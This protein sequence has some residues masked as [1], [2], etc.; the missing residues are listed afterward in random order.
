MFFCPL[1]R[2]LQP[3]IG[4]PSKYLS[5]RLYARPLTTSSATLAQQNLLADTTYEEEWAS[6][7]EYN[8]I[9]GPTSIGLMMD[10]LPGGE[11]Y[12]A[13]FLKLYAT[14]RKRYGDLFVFRGSFGRAD[15][16]CTYNPIDFEKVYRT[17]GVWPVRDGVGSFKHYRKVENPKAY[18]G[19]LGL[20]AEQGEGWFN[21]RQKVNPILM[22]VQNMREALPEIDRI[23]MEL[24]EKIGTV[25]D[26][27]TGLLTADFSNEMRMWSFESICYVALNSRLH[28]ITGKADADAMRMSSTTA[29]FMQATYEHDIAPSIWRIIKT[30]SFKRLMRLH[31]DL[32]MITRKLIDKALERIEAEGRKEA[33]SVLEKLL[34]V[35]KNIAVVMVI[36]MLFGGLDTTSSTVIIA[37]FLLAKNPEKQNILR[38]ELRTLLPNVDTPLVAQNLQ[39]IPYLR[40]CIKESMR[41]TPII[42]GTMRATGRD[43]VLSGYRVPKDTGVHMRN[44]ELCNSDT[45]FARCSE[46]L[47]E[48]WLKT[49]KNVSSANDA[50]KMQ[51]PFVYLPFGFGPRTCVGRRLADLEMEVLLARLFRKYKIT[52]TDEK[53]DLEYK[54]NLILTPCGEMKFKFEEVD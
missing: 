45:F 35:D 50:A 34:R 48:R 21:I 24:V 25:R 11:L 26:P 28:L 8:E 31:D 13:N 53:N 18:G 30:P 37:I 41:I 39:N 43:L 23:A 6:A 20:V 15:L 14:M 4:V 29:E 52:W 46:Y 19:T 7:K 49:P 44:M 47:P 36:D 51:N 9:P 27:K 38:E 10:F 17:E 32:T 33:V 5:P 16:V 2:Y 22:K 42:S 1:H 40:A 54:S 12:G 3:L